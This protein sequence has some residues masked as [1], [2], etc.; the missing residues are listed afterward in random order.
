MWLE[1]LNHAIVCDLVRRN[2]RA[3]AALP[4]A[5][6]AECDHEQMLQALAYHFSG[7]I[8]PVTDERGD[9]LRRVG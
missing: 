5:S 4:I 8:S 3:R 1:W 7:E 2:E 9:D 6:F